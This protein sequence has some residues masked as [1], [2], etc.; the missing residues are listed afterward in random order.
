M[1]S[2]KNTKKNEFAIRENAWKN[3]YRDG[4]WFCKGCCS[5]WTLCAKWPINSFLIFKWHGKSDKP[6]KENV[7]QFGQHIA[8]P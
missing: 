6:D 5:D 4:S 7:G 1:E 2:I 3:S 8:L